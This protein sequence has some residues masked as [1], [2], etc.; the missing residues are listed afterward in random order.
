MKLDLKGNKTARGQMGH[1]G[2]EISFFKEGNFQFVNKQRRNIE[3]SN[4]E[5]CKIIQNICKFRRN[6]ALQ[7]ANLPPKLGEFPGMQSGP[8]HMCLMFSNTY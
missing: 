7:S 8:N 1:A 5:I 4:K 6:T 3:T 2:R